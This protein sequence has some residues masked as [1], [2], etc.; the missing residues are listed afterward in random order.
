LFALVNSVRSIKGVQ[1]GTITIEPE[2]TVFEVPKEHTTTFVNCLN[3]KIIGGTKLTA[4][5]VGVPTQ[6]AKNPTVRGTNMTPKSAAPSKK[7]STKNKY[8]KLKK[9]E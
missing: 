2:Q 9:K 3:G 8:L 4:E 6:D 7:P 1:I 5:L